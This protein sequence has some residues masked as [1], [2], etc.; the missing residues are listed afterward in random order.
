MNDKEI[1]KYAKN[2]IIANLNQYE[3]KDPSGVLSAIYNIENDKTN[4][5]LLKNI[6]TNINLLQKAKEIIKKGGK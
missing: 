4:M 3:E 6:E 2:L 5:S 1:L